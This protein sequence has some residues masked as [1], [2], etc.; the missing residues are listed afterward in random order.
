MHLPKAPVAWTR[1]TL[2]PDS[3][4]WHLNPQPVVPALHNV[5]E[6]FDR[7]R[8]KDHGE[9]L[10]GSYFHLAYG[11]AGHFGHLMT[12]AVAKLWGWWP[13]KEADPDLK[14]LVR[15]RH[16]T[17]EPG[18]EA[19]APARL[20]HLARRHRVDRRPGHRDEPGRLHPDV[21][22]RAALLRPPRDPRD[23]GPAPRGLLGTET[24]D[25]APR[26]FVTRRA[27]QPTLQQRRGGRAA[28][29]R[30]RLRDRGP[31]GAELRRAGGDVRRGAR[32]RRL[33]RGRDV[34]PRVR[35]SRSRRSSC[36]TSRPTTRA[37][38]C[39]TPRST[40]PTCTRF[41]SS[42]DHQHPPGGY[43]PRAHQSPWTFDLGL[44]GRA[45]RPAS[46]RGWFNDAHADRPDRRRLPAQL[47]PHGRRRTAGRARPRRGCRRHGAA[48]L[49][50]V[51]EPTTSTSGPAARSRT[52]EAGATVAV[53]VAPERVADGVWHLRLRE[54]A[55]SP[56]RELGA[57]VLVHGDQ[58]VALLF[59][60]TDQRLRRSQ[61]GVASP[62][63]A[64]RRATSGRASAAGF[65]RSRCRPSQIGARSR[66]S[67]SKARVRPST[68]SGMA[69]GS[70]T[71]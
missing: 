36:S 49:R 61:R 20:R 31:R 24:V 7:L 34:Q 5:D 39:C 48:G 62:A 51:P 67:G 9:T 64:S 43:S 44:N 38:S 59:G 40:A 42:P 70:G 25:V 8:L 4:R 46:R 21:A 57:R 58:P 56:L 50:P 18:L 47:R 19:T 65:S 53:T 27:V 3:L 6:H 12:E 10:E 11:P 14:I 52:P 26:I 66:S 32:G 1:R 69:C 29:R 2:L 28:L 13:A 55:G 30:P 54:D 16:L 22:Q 68:S 33:R 35:E 63:S 71:T 15:R 17:G 41:W 60:K 37:T 23:L 45:A